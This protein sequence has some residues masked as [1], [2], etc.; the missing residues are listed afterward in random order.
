MIFIAQLAFQ[1]SRSLGAR[2][3]ANDNIH[4]S[5]AWTAIIQALWLVTTCMGVKAVDQSDWPSVAG[6]ML[7]GVAGVYINFLVKPPN[8]INKNKS[9]EG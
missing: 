4:S 2:Y 6:Y 7:G 9:K 5:A 8:T 1:F 3:V